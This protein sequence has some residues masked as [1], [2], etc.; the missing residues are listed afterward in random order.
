MEKDIANS[1]VRLTWREVDA[2]HREL[3]KKIGQD[4]LAKPDVIV[5]I[6]R[7][8]LPTATHIAYLC[9]VPSILV[10]QISKGYHEISSTEPRAQVGVDQLTGSAVFSAIYGKR[11]L[12]IDGAIGSGETLSLAYSLILKSQPAKIGA[13]VLAGWSGCPKY[14]ND[15][16]PELAP[17]LVGKEY[18]P[19]P[20][21]PWEE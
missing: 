7:G 6:A 12:L 20:V 1:G 3:A 16:T 11:V 21:F 10:V 14:R 19:W 13:A 18:F 17:L 2:I 9:E 8:G 15:L 4:A 5:A